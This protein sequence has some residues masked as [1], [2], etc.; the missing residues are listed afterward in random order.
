MRTQRFGISTVV[1]IMTILL[2]LSLAVT[3]FA[4]AESI[5]SPPIETTNIDDIERYMECNAYV[6]SMME[7]IYTGVFPERIMTNTNT[8]YYYHYACQPFGNPEFS[9]SL[10]LCF[11]DCNDYKTEKQRVFTL[12]GRSLEIDMPPT[13]VYFLSGSPDEVIDYFD[14][15]IYDGKSYNFEIVSFDDNKLVIEYYISQLWE[16][17]RASSEQDILCTFVDW[18]SE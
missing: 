16:G 1:A 17:Q 8:D 2:V 7:S 14:D 5:S 15:Q 6:L 12:L 18:I 4:K 13:E 3:S 11:N 9:L 10:K